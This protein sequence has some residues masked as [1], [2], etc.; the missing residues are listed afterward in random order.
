MYLLQNIRNTLFFTKAIARFFSD[1][2]RRGS[3]VANLK[4]VIKNKEISEDMSWAEL[5]EEKAS[6][7]RDNIFLL[8]ED[9]QFTYG[10]MDENA[11]RIANFLKSFGGT[12]GKGVAIMMGNSPQFLDVFFGS[13]KLGMYSIPINTSLRGDSLQYILNHSDAELLVLD[14]EFLDVFNKIADRAQNIKTVIV[15]RSV[16][17]SKS[18]LPKGIIDLAKAYSL[19]AQKPF[20][21]H[22]KD[23]VCFILYTSGTTGLPKGVVYRYGKSTVK[24]LSVPSYAFYKKSDVF[25]T[26]LPLFHG[27][28]LFVT[29]TQCMH[30]G[31]KVAIAKKFSASRFW[32]DIRK[33]DVTAFNTIGAMIPILMKQPQKSNDRDNK[34]RFTLSS[35]CPVD[36]W[37]KF[38][39][40]FG[41][42]IYESYGAVDGG[43]KTIWNLGN[44]P[45]GSIGKPSPNTK[46]RL[47]DKDGNDVPDGTPGQLIFESRG[48]KKSVEYFKNEKAS[49]EK[50]RNGW[51]YTGDLVKRDSKGY[52]YFVGRNAEFMRI[53]GENV[54]AYEVEH[55]IQKHP[56]VLEAAVYAVPSE[57]AEDEIM[58]CVSVVSG[59]QLN[60]S[61]LIAFL[62]EDLPKFAVPRF[63]KIVKEF[64]KTETQRIKKKELEKIGIVPGTYDAQK[65]VYIAV[66]KAS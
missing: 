54:S 34:A 14:E 5:L 62:K 9:K 11:N 66:S 55:T 47:V 43:G 41:I 59:H 6:K 2:I 21:T 50:L 48:K 1:E 56:S 35:A 64:P 29:V 10:R 45:V 26:C 24:L 28:A 31:A 51:I 20:G 60:E 40:R 65:N 8:F 33:Y 39:K 46:Y 7:H 16:P 42:K 12:R 4:S 58:T 36:E 13:Q 61:E 37:E 19:S 27:N 23:D 57:L 44:A 18:A 25:Y 32:D 63:V 30:Q 15:N 3:F 49:N 52:L 17:P 38:E 53:K 22:D